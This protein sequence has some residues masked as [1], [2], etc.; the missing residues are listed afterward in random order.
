MSLEL[1]LLA[2]IAEMDLSSFHLSF[3]Q[4]CQSIWLA[5]PKA[6]L[7]LISRDLGNVVSSFSIGRYRK[8]SGN[9]VF[10]ARLP[11]SPQEKV[12]KVQALQSDSLNLLLISFLTLS[13]LPFLFISYLCHIIGIYPMGLF[14]NLMKSV[15]R[16]KLILTQMF[17]VICW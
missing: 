10:G 3:F 13:K 17:G 16:L 15:V 7:K 11:H 5:K 1:F 8:G 14:E 9:V 12:L 2:H 6:R 4:I